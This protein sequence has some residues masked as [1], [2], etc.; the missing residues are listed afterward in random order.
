MTDPLDLSLELDYRHGLGDFAPYFRAL[1]QG[2]LIAAECPKCA[3]SW[4]PPRPRCCEDG[5]VTEP[6]Q[7][8]GTGTVHAETLTTARLPFTETEGPVRFALVALDGVSGLTLGRMCDPEADVAPG[9]RVQLAPLETEP[10]H[11]AQALIFEPI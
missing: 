5:T 6:K 2:R 11:P 3:R 7:L 4:C 10:V 1:L 9:M 8:A